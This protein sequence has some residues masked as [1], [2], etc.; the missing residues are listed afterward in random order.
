MPVMARRP[1]RRAVCHGDRRPGADR[2][3]GF[4]QLGTHT[5]CLGLIGADDGAAVDDVA[6]SICL[7][8]TSVPRPGGW[9][10][11]G[12]GERACRPSRSPPESRRSAAY[13][14]TL[15]VNVDNQELETADSSHFMTVPYFANPAVVPAALSYSYAEGRLVCGAAKVL[16]RLLELLAQASCLRYRAAKLLSL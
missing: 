15:Q 13:R 6:R 8:T 9:L 1:L 14:D 3:V 7:R 2:H 4:E 11:H 16:G 10:H 5:E 12:R